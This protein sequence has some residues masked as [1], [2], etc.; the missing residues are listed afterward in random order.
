MKLVDAI[1]KPILSYAS[2]VWCQQ[3]IK[4]IYNANIHKCDSLAFEKLYNTTCKQI[5][6]VGKYNNYLAARLELGRLSISMF[7]KKK[8]SFEVLEEVGEISTIVNII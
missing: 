4:Q 7:N 3:F 5:L 8:K 6:G 2:D 1:V